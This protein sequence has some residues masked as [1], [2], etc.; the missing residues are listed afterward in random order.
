MVNTTVTR[1]N[2]HPSSQ[3]ATTRV[4]RG[5]AGFQFLAETTLREL[6]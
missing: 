2:L 4:Q 6:K 5:G 1:Q 3:L